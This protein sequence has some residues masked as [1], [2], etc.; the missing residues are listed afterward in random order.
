MKRT[1]LAI[2]ALAVVLTL[3]LPC[4]LAEETP[5]ESGLSAALDQAMQDEQDI[6]GF[7]EDA[8]AAYPDARP[9][10]A[11]LR[12][13]AVHISLLERVAKDNGLTLQVTPRDIAVPATLE[14]TLALAAQLEQDDIKLYEQ[15]LT[16]ATLPQDSVKAFQRLRNA[17]ER[18]LNA[19]QR[20]SGSDS[21][22]RGM[23]GNGRMRDNGIRGKDDSESGANTPQPRFGQGFR[24]NG[25][26]QQPF[27]FYRHMR[28]RMRETAPRCP[29]ENCPRR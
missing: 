10:A 17:S 1:F 25:D 27:R 7:Y 23:Q 15:L 18:H 16:D 9:F 24:R 12:S 20:V 19:L 28:D 13:E 3:S 8:L 6:R 5:A 2:L 11:L 4:A 21:L 22:N 14:E 26:P 29:C